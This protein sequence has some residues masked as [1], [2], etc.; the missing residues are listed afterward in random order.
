[1]FVSKLKRKEIL[2]KSLDNYGYI[3]VTDTMQDAIDTANDI[4][5]EHLEIVTKNPLIQ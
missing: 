2:Q 4:A 3:L 1:M 5:S